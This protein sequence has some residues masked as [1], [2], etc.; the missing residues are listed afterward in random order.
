MVSEATGKLSA[1]MEQGGPS[2]RSPAGLCASDILS[3]RDLGAW[4]GRPLGWGCWVPFT[5][6]HPRKLLSTHQELPA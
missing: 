1:Q 4:A 5:S 6:H 2:D 3:Q